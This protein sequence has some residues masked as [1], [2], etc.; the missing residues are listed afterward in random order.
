MKINWKFHGGVLLRG[1]LMIL[2]GVLPVILIALLL[3][4]VGVRLGPYDLSINPS[5][6]LIL[7]GLLALYCGSRVSSWINNN[8]RMGQ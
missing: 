4:M 2:F 1:F 5:V 3:A 7:Y 6:L 8:I